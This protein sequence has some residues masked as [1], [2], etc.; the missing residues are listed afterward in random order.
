[1]PRAILSLIYTRLLRWENTQQVEVVLAFLGVGW[2]VQ[3]H[4]YGSIYQ[5]ILP[6]HLVVIALLASAAVHLV[7]L[8]AGWIHWRKVAL[9]AEAVIWTALFV[10]ILRFGAVSFTYAV[11]ALAGIWAYLVFSRTAALRGDGSK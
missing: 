4:F 1:M 7:G 10:T 5:Q 2:V 6:L 8:L 9:S 3:F 11:L